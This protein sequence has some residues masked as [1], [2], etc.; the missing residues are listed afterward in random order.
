MPK[1]T[2]AILPWNPGAVGVQQMAGKSIDHAVADNAASVGEVEIFVLPAGAVVQQVLVDVTEAFN[3]SANTLTV[4]WDAERDN[5][6]SAGSSVNLTSAGLKVPV[7]TPARASADVTVYA[8]Y[9]Q[10]GDPEANAGAAT[11]MVVYTRTK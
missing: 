9:S 8:K 6:V 7:I 1:E 4:G 3:A 5:L 10:A 2:I 11:V